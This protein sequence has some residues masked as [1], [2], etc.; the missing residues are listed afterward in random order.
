MTVKK[1]EENNNFFLKK[2]KPK[3]KIVWES[4]FEGQSAHDFDNIVYASDNA[5]L[6]FSNMHHETKPSSN[7]FKRR[8][9]KTFQKNKKREEYIRDL[10]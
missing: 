1:T 6:S 9:N 2:K 3:F 7:S 10:E 5:V 4:N 8:A